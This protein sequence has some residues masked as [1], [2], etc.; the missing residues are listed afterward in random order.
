MNKSFLLNEITL[1]KSN[2]ITGS[3]QISQPN[4]FTSTTPWPFSPDMVVVL[5]TGSS[6]C[7]W[8]EIFTHFKGQAFS[9]GRIGES[10]AMDEVAFDF[11]FKVGEIQLLVDFLTRHYAQAFAIDCSALPVDQLATFKDKRPFFFNVFVDEPP[12][13]RYSRYLE[14]FGRV[15]LKGANASETDVNETNAQDTNV[16]E[17]NIQETESVEMPEVTVD[18]E[19]CRTPEKCSLSPLKLSPSTSQ[20]SQSTTHPLSLASFLELEGSRFYG[21]RRLK[22]ITWI[23]LGQQPVADIFQGIN[24]REAVRPSWDRYF[25]LLARHAASRSNCMKKKVGCIV[26]Q[27]FRIIATG[28]NGTP[29]S[30]P[31]CNEG[32]C[33]RCNN[34][35]I[36][37]GQRLEECFCIHAEE[38]ALLECGKNALGATLYCSTCPCIGCAKKI[39]QV[40]ISRVF[41]SDTFHMDDIAHFIFGQAKVEVQR[42]RYE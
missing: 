24:L 30:M 41:Y 4:H 23:L 11:S 16:N 42:F 1:S 34:P 12:V 21:A 31:N 32:G 29:Y 27:N 38:N 6:Y 37:G 13:R 22:N 28:Y 7:N 20:P 26:A 36:K 39:V 35:D 40:G 18:V 14:E 5:I 33:P 3:N 25:M 19:R 15:P 9:L 8:K 2:Q 10:Q 17:T